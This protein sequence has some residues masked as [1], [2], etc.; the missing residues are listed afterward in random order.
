MAQKVLGGNNRGLLAERTVNPVKA[1]TTSAL[2][3]MPPGRGLPRAGCELAVPAGSC[4]Q[5]LHWVPVVLSSASTSHLAPFSF[6]PEC[7]G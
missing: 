5:G 2:G 4:W 7:G 6:L 1:H 3:T